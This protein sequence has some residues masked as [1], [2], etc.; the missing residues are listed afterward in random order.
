MT[1]VRQKFSL[2]KTCSERVEVQLASYPGSNRFAVYRPATSP[3]DRSTI[4]FG[5]IQR[6]QQPHEPLIPVITP[7]LQTL[8]FVHVSLGGS[9]GAAVTIDGRMFVW[10]D[11]LGEFGIRVRRQAVGLDHVQRIPREV[12]FFAREGMVCAGVAL[13]G[14]HACAWGVCLEPEPEVC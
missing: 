10:G 14:R 3:S 6:A 5:S 1:E 13:G 11:N 2:T 4:L 9:R 7:L 12:P 8:P